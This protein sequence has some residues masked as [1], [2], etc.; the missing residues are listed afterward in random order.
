MN[1]SMPLN[2]KV[3]RLNGSFKVAGFI[4][5]H[6]SN[7]TWICTCGHGGCEH[8]H[9]VENEFFR[10]KEEAPSKRKEMRQESGATPSAELLQ[11]LY[12]IGVIPHTAPPGAIEGFLR[13]CNETGLS[14]LKKQ[15]RLMERWSAKDQGTYWSIEPSLDGYRTIAERSGK[16]A[17]SD[18]PVFEGKI[19]GKIPERCTVTVWKIVQATRCAFT[20]TAYWQDYFQKSDK[21]RAEFYET[22]P[23]IALARDAEVIALKKAWP[24]LGGGSIVEDPD[25]ESRAGGAPS[26]GTPSE[27]SAAQPKPK[28]Q[29]VI[30]SQQETIIAM[31]KELSLDPEEWAQQTFGKKFAKLNFSQAG[32]AIQRLTEMLVARGAQTDTRTEPDE[33]E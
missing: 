2:L 29:K 5:Q 33:S 28:Q 8:I 1:V 27:A 7:D 11:S 16:Y 24:G 3:E 32:A 30:P 4:V 6:I 23:H 21:S 15:A 19:N 25:Q 13:Y 9:A 20:G 26:Y 17:G 14:A 22:R 12:T 10:L 18:A 31:C